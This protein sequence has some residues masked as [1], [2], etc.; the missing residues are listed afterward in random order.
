[1]Q[2][3]YLLRAQKQVN[4]QFYELTGHARTPV[5]RSEWFDL[6]AD[7]DVTMVKENLAN[8]TESRKSDEVQFR[9]KKTWVD[10][11]GIR[12][13]IWVQSSGFPQVDEQGKVM[14]IYL[15]CQVI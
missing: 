8:M 7:E 1:M 10:Q 13:N 15:L 6:I 3:M 11:D 9:L 5:G 4:E 2:D 12:S 14:S